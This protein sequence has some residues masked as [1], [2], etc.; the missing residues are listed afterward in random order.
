MGIDWLAFVTVAL[1][2]VV[3]SCFV[4]AVYSVGLRFWSAADT[5]AGK[6][7]VKDDGTI[8]PATVGFPNPQGATAAVRAFRSLAVLC[9][10][11]CGAVVLYGI[12]LIVPQFH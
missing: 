1:V 11:V 12:Y 4:V 6:F 7:T 3:S 2:A 5:R 9:F 10:A 8:G